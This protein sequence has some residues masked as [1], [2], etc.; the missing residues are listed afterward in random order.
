MLPGKLSHSI[1]DGRRRCNI[2]VQSLA[3]LF[4]KSQ[5]VDNFLGLASHNVSVTVFPTVAQKQPCV[6]C[7]CMSVVRVQ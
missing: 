3:K 6:I 2:L 4:H 1:S 7:E 5:V